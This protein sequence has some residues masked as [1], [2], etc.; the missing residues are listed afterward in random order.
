MR[1]VAVLTLLLTLTACGGDPE[2][3][4]D[5]APASSASSAP[6][7][8]SPTPTPTPEEVHTAASVAETIAASVDVRT[9]T[10]TEDNDPNDLIGR[11]NGYVAAVVLKDGRVADCGSDLGV[12]CGATLEEWPDAAAAKKRSDYIQDILAGSSMLGSEYHY[13]V[14]AVLVRVTGELKPSQA[15]EYEAAVTA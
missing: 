7:S 2:P 12:D 14:G 10:I 11:P 3:D 9:V 8:T 4:A 15:A 1:S 13:F 5:P 6:P